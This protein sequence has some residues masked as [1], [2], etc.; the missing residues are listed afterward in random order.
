[1]LCKFFFACIEFVISA[2]H[3]EELVVGA[4]F[5]DLAVFEHHDGVGVTHGGKAVRDH[6]SGA[7]FHQAFHAVLDVALGTGWRGGEPVGLWDPQFNR[8]YTYAGFANGL[9]GGI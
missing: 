1:M 8:K 4:A 3:G 9:K 7:V 2:F 5:D 6:E